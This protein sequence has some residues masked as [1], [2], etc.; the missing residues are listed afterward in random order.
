MLG[1]L[2]ENGRRV[3]LMRISQRWRKGNTSPFLSLVCIVALGAS[4]RLHGIGSTPRALNPDEAYEGLDALKI[5]GGERPIFLA[6]NRGREALY[7][8]LVAASI[9]VLGRTPGAIRLVGV[10]ADLGTIA[11]VFLAIRVVYDTRTSLLAGL[12]H[13]IT[14]WPILVSRFGT[15]V[16]TLPLVL[17]FCL[18]QGVLAWRS[19]RPGNWLAAGWLLGLAF[20]TYTPIRLFPLAIVLFSVY[21]ALRRQWARLWPGALYGLLMAGVTVLPFAVY[22]AAHPTLVFGR[23]ADV[24]VIKV[25]TPPASVF[26]LLASQTY[27]VLRMFL[28][29]GDWNPRQDIW[30]AGTLMVPRPV[31]DPVMGTAF[32]LG[33][34]VMLR[35]WRQ[36]STFLCYAWAGVMLLPT[37]L[38]D[39][40]PHFGRAAGIL[41]VVFV[42]PAL[43]LFALRDWLTRH[44][45]RLLANI[46]TASLVGLSVFFSFRDLILS[47]YLSQPWLSSNYYG[48]PA[49][50]VTVTINR[51]LGQ[52]W[53]GSNLRAQPASDSGGRAV[54]VAEELTQSAAF[55]FLVNR[56]DPTIRGLLPGASPP[57]VS[58]ETLILVP[59][60][61]PVDLLTALPPGAIKQQWQG[62]WSWS[63]PGNEVGAPLFDAYLVSLERP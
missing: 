55:T 24:S 29:S 42:W 3:A 38:S 46:F 13:A 35:R 10:L 51:F 61:Q 43:G 57:A 39:E 4:I 8:Y 34:L 11:G 28:F 53:T 32:I 50:D 33:H 41:P 58:K 48:G 14:V 62:G 2:G 31:F 26:S 27:K 5:I 45:G 17:V 59:T 52:G 47:G 21:L 7:G 15:R 25:G 40:A 9:S 63:A 19:R 36:P 18:W 22:A 6:G 1:R 23:S 44:G 49:T 12:I 37:V 16:S 60:G 56:N 20:Y 30:Y 54:L